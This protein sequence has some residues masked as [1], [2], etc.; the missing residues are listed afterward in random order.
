MSCA[1][2]KRFPTAILFACALFAAGLEKR[3]V[4]PPSAK[5]IGPYSPG[6]FAGEFLYV[7]GQGA[8]GPNGQIPATFE[9]QA[10]QSFENVKSIV[11][12]AGLTME[13]VVYSHVYLENAANYDAMNKVWAQYFSRGIPPA[14]ATVGVHKMPTDTP[15]ELNAVCVRD[16]S[17]KKAIVPAGY[18]ANAALSPGVMVGDRL[19]L[20]GFLGRE[21]N[22]GKI[23][24]DPAAQVQLAL[25]RVKQTLAEAGMD[26]RHMVFINPYHT[27]AMP[28]DV[29][30]R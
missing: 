30:N 15:F 9:E 22:T 13:H 26:F 2:S 21:I 1:P 5:P 10:R 8:R 7:S 18:P 16:L 29:M 27:R 19:Y 3:V 14:R 4:F 17:S 24:D 23:P 6:I 12:T 28:T 25:D 11:E 20:S